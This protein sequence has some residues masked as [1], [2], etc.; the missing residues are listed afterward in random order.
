MKKK[1]ID[2][3]LKRFK[4]KYLKYILYKNHYNG[5]IYSMHLRIFIIKVQKKGLVS[6]MFYLSIIFLCDFYHNFV[7]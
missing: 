5:G 4:S 1:K 3:V 2:G 7:Y 6:C